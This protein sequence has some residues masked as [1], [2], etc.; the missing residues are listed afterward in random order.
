MDSAALD[1]FRFSTAHGRSLKA[2]PS[3]SS[4]PGRAADQAWPLLGFCWPAAG[5]H[6]QQKHQWFGGKPCFLQHTWQ[7]EAGDKE[8]GETCWQCTSWK[9]HPIRKSPASQTYLCCLSPTPTA[10]HGPA[11]LCFLATSRGGQPCGPSLGWPMGCSCGS[12]SQEVRL[13]WQSSWDPK[14]LWSCSLPPVSSVAS[15]QFRKLR[16]KALSKEVRSVWE[17]SR[18]A[19]FTRVANTAW[20]DVRKRSLI[21]FSNLLLETGFCPSTC[22]KYNWLR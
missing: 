16:R 7:V 10:Q 8:A 18:A 4:S 13:T 3:P 22:C 5:N 19:N 17:D 12:L 9:S 21:C 14:K 1:T 15:S 6:L 2:H 11:A 20:A